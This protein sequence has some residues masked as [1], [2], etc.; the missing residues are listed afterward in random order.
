MVLI[1]IF[2][3]ETQLT[4]VL[5]HDAM[6]YLAQGQALINLLKTKKLSAQTLP[7]KSRGSQGSHTL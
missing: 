2:C 6:V 4:S 1:M 5:T 7:L 3:F